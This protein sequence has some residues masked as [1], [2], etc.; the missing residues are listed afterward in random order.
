MKNIHLLPTD[1]SNDGYIIGKCIKGLSD[2]KLGQFVR[3]YYLMFDKDY[4]QPH[5]IHIT[6]DEDI[7][8]GDWCI[9]EDGIRKCTAH[10]GAMNHYYSKIILTT[11]PDLI[12]DGVQAIDDKFLEW[13]IKN[14][15]CEYAVVKK[16][17]KV[18]AIVKG[19]GIKSFDNGYKI[20]IPR[21]EI[22]LDEVFNDEKREGVKK[23]I[24]T[25]KEIRRILDGL[26]IEKLKEPNSFL[27]GVKCQDEKS[28]RKWSNEE[29]V[30][31]LWLLYSSPN[32]EVDF[33]T[34]EELAEWF[35]KFKK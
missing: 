18:R 27:N 5:N 19:F 31:L 10:A 23:F 17:P 4:F 8:E 12:K 6:S 9:D 28:D 11:D 3:T 2:V 24:D 7:Q 29:V 30:D 35:N 32:R 25:H 14:P 26:S 15:N 22:R 16:N 34:R 13:F 33:T 21:K 20:I 1:R